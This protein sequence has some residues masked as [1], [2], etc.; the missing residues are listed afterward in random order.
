MTDQE[1]LLDKASKLAWRKF[2]ASDAGKDGLLYL[3]FKIPPI[4]AGDANAIV[5]SAGKVEGFRDAIYTITKEITKLETEK[6]IK[7]END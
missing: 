4:R 5:F 6:D 2:L 7:T 1:P 3:S